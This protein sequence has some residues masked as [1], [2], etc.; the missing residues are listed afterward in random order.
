MVWLMATFLLLASLAG[1]FSPA[2]AVGEGLVLWVGRLS[3]SLSLAML[4]LAWSI[5]PPVRVAF[6]R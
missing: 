2:G 1:A 6:P 4:V 3:L 5:A